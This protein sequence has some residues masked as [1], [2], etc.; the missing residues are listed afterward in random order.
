[1]LE[2]LVR[3]NPLLFLLFRWSKGKVRDK[4]SN[5]V[6]FDKASYEKLYKEASCF[7]EISFNGNI[8]ISDCHFQIDHSVRRLRAFEG[9]RFVGHCCFASTSKWRLDQ[10]RCQTRI[11][12]GLYSRYKGRCWR[13]NN[14]SNVYCF[15]LLCYV[16]VNK[17]KSVVLIVGFGSDIS[18]IIS[19]KFKHRLKVYCI[20]KI[21]V[22]AQF[23]YIWYDKNLFI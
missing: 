14:I 12:T 11:S 9:S 20:F 1:M 8:L 7:S 19:R 21:L 13:I 2:F 18:W 3:V 17:Y 23:R 10:V 6:L 15:I 4:L 22:K 16:T 5:A